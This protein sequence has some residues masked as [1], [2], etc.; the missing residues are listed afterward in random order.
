MLPTFVR[1][2]L[3]DLRARFGLDGWVLTRTIEGDS[4]I[5]FAAGEAI[6]LEGTTHPWAGSLEGVLISGGALVI[7]DLSASPHNRATA[8]L[9]G[10][11]SF[12][13]TP[14]H[15]SDGE[16]FGSL[17]G[18]GTAPL[19]LDEDAVRRGM[20]VAS[21]SLRAVLAVSD[22]LAAAR[23]A[24]TAGR[25]DV[26]RD[27]LT[28][29]LNERGWD[30]ALQT[31]QERCRR[32]GNRGSVIRLIVR[33]MADTP[34]AP[35]SGPGDLLIRQVG[36]ALRDWRRGADVVAR[37]ADGTFAVL[38]VEAWEDDAAAAVRRLEQTLS[39]RRIVGA[40]GLA[41]NQSRS[42]VEAVEIA[43]DRAVSAL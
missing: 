25:A 43:H 10:T 6:A 21:R 33:G 11:R 1:D 37:L 36:D 2:L 41:D 30:D 42:L 12:I 20:S 9:P 39:A 32:Y 22:A 18:V 23:P 29:L 15:T 38:L 28:G 5:I 35:G 17:Y 13:G 8:I 3:D 14:V 34:L 26:R 40:I 27:P 7:G 31:E 16:L 19:E 24:E 4:M